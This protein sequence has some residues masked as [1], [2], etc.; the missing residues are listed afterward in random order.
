MSVQVHMS[1]MDVLGEGAEGTRLEEK[2]EREREGVNMCCK[3]VRVQSVFTETSEKY[4]TDPGFREHNQSLIHTNTFNLRTTFLVNYL[5]RNVPCSGRSTLCRPLGLN[6]FSVCP[7]CVSMEYLWTCQIFH[8]SLIRHFQKRDI[9]NR[10]S[11]S[12]AR[13][14][15]LPILRCFRS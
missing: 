6:C 14:S 10:C 4:V 11:V 9:K 1:D 2:R 8:F 15:F 7:V 3:L 13:F 12:I 5:A